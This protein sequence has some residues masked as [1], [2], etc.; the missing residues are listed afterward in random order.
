MIF[1]LTTPTK[2]YG[3][4]HFIMGE[5]LYQMC[6]L[7]F[8]KSSALLQFPHLFNQN[9]LL[10]G[11]NSITIIGGSS[12]GI[13]GTCPTFV[14]NGV[15]KYRNIL[16]PLAQLPHPFISTHLLEPQLPPLVFFLNPQLPQVEPFPNKRKSFSLL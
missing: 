3:K 13:S 7:D 9:K 2:D 10:Y 4:L 12:W 11:K 6:V 16:S 8:D 14:I 5:I 15:I 1:Y